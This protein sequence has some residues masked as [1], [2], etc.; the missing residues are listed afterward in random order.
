[1]GVCVAGI[2][3]ARSSGICQFRL[4]LPERHRAEGHGACLLSL[5]MSPQAEEMD[6]FAKQVIAPMK[7]PTP[8]RT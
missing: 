7:A 2:S 5:E 6:R 3:E 8:G 4:A 1:M